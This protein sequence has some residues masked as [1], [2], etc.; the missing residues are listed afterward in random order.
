MTGS[1][2]TGYFTPARTIINLDGLISGVEYFEALR[3]GTAAEYLEGI[4]LDYVF[5]NEYVLLETQPY[6]EVFTGNMTL[7]RNWPDS[8]RPLRLWRFAP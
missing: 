6:R 8:D 5:G 7:L 2:S 4:G 1:G 3:D